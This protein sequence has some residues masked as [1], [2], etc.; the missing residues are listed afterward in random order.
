[1][2]NKIIKQLVKMKM[3]GNN[4]EFDSYEEVVNK[5][6]LDN[7]EDVKIVFTNGVFDLLHPG[8]L[9]SLNFCKEQVGKDGIVIVGINDDESVKRLKGE[10]RPILDEWARG[11][12]LL[13]LKSVD[14]VIIFSEDTPKELIEVLKPDIIVKSGDYRIENV[15]GN[16]IAEVKIAPFDNEYST[17]KI[18]EKIMEG[19]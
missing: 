2:N 5:I 8:H 14:Y 10:R 4:F 12:L 16:N 7:K 15:V 9:L 18:I 3:F 6:R 17:T 13:A 11:T 19:K 1:M